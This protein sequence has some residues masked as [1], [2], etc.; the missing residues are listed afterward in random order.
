MAKSYTKASTVIVGDRLEA[1][2]QG[3]HNFGIDSV[4]FNPELKERGN[5]PVSR[6]EIS[7]L[8]ELKTLWS[9]L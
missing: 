5:S 6:F 7:H 4:W 1:D 8:S 9:R 2:I 3:A